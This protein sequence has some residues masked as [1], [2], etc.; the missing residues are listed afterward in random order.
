MKGKE[1][2]TFI[3]D[4]AGGNPVVNC[5]G[6][7]ITLVLPNTGIQIYIPT[8]KYELNVDFSNNGHGVLRDV[9]VKP[10]IGELL[11]GQDPV[12]NST[13]KLIRESAN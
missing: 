3:G 9:L 7:V 13:L 12:L 11:S 6:K 10:T 5:A 8:T 1:I 2:G 4:E